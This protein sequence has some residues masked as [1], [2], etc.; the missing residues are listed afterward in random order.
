V[1]GCPVKIEL[2]TFVD[3][4]VVTWQPLPGGAS[5]AGVM[6]APVRHDRSFEL[7]AGLFGSPHRAL[8]VSEMETRL[9]SGAPASAGCIHALDLLHRV[10]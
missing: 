10:R 1:A 4:P 8:V 3:I 2:D 9:A 6:P 7:I 5:S